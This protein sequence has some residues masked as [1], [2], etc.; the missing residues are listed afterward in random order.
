M[1]QFKLPQ[2]SEE[3]QALLSLT[4]FEARPRGFGW[5]VGKPNWVAFYFVDRG[6]VTLEQWRAAIDG[7]IMA[8]A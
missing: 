1:V 4:G 5:H 3:V 2:L 7:I 8:H 6:T